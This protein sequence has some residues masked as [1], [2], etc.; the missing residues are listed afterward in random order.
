ML[1]ALKQ[2]L[3]WMLHPT[4][5]FKDLA[6]VDALN[7]GGI[8]LWSVHMIWFPATVYE[9]IT[10]ILGWGVAVSLIAL[11]VKKYREKERRTKNED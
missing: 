5:E 10:T 11:N 3:E 4:G 2:F 6:E 1:H 8:T 7:I 9:L